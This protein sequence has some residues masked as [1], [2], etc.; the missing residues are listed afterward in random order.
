M[1]DLRT[2][3]IA[4][5]SNL[6]DRHAYLENA[7]SAI[8]SIRGTRCI[9]ETPVEETAAIGPIKQAPFLNQ[10]LA[11]ETELT[12]EDLLR[13]L[14][15]IEESAGRVRGA[16]W[17]PRTLDLD[18]VAVDG[19]AISSPELV[20]P[21]PELPHREFWLRELAMLRRSMKPPR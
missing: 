15:R 20:V 7:R 13:E 3:Y 16:R 8:R 21:H 5:G 14:Q 2:A 17:G 1:T 6:G 19:K 11:V 9:A 4:L 12:P 18:I 10:M